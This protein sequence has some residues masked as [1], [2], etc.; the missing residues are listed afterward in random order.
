[1]D[2][3]RLCLQQDESLLDTGGG[4]GAVSKGWERGAQSLYEQTMESQRE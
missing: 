4:G 1:M 2:E 3:R